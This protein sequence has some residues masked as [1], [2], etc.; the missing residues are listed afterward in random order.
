MNIIPSE[1]RYYILLKHTIEPLK[2]LK[3]KKNPKIISIAYMIFILSGFI[4]AQMVSDA[5][6]LSKITSQP[7]YEEII[8]SEVEWILE[9]Q[10]DLPD[11]TSNG[12]IVMNLVAYGENR[13]MPYFSNFA[14]MGLLARPQ[15]APEVKLWM[16]WYFAHMNFPDRNGVEGTIYDYIITMPAGTEE[17][18]MSGGK[19]HFDS[20]DSY[21]S[22][23]LVLLKKYYQVTGNDDYLIDNR[24]NIEI[25]ADVMVSVQQSDGLTWAITDYK[26][27]YLMDNAEVYEGFE[28]IEWITRNVYNDKDKADYWEE[29][30]NAVADGVENKL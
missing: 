24:E 8:D 27:K 13:V 22:T 26:V 3:K 1:S 12:A 15:Y 21:A 10:I 30:K 20:I 17:I 14:A 28:A 23:F 4:N 16:D 25:I 5:S 9:Q 18:M 2:C 6:Y 7:D 11:E 29:C 19:E